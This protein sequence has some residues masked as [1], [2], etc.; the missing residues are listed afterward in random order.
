[1]PASPVCTFCDRPAFL[2][3][4]VRPSMCEQHADLARLICVLESFGQ[5]ASVERVE[6]EVRIRQDCISIQPRE[7]AGLMSQ[8]EGNHGTQLHSA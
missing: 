3:G 4:V 8:M 5:V 6:Q 1:M 7:V 2:P